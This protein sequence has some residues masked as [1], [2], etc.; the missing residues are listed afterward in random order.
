MYGTTWTA[1]V[2]GNARSMRA[3]RTK[4]IASTRRWTAPASMPSR[5][6]PWVFDETACS[7]C[8]LSGPD[9]PTTWTRVTSNADDIR[10]PQ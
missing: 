10:R 7:I 9:V 6:L 4:G 2:C 8:A 1:S 3:E 5:L